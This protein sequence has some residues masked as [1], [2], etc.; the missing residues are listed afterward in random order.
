MGKLSLIMLAPT[1][2]KRG[3]RWYLFKSILPLIESSKPLWGGCY[4][5][6]HSPVASSEMSSC[7]P[8]PVDLR[9]NSSV[10]IDRSSELFLCFQLAKAKIIHRFKYVQYYYLAHQNFPL[11][12]NQISIFP[13]ALFCQLKPLSFRHWRA[14]TFLQT[15]IIGSTLSSG[16][17]EAKHDTE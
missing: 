11:I 16:A 1:I 15:F 10:S 3:T 17:N 9:S 7:L 14:T 13:I 6:L 4:C 2:R 12:L 8:G 5:T